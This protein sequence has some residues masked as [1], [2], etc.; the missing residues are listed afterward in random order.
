LSGFLITG[1]L[2]DEKS[3]KFSDY[4]RS[5]Y[6]KRTL[7]I[8]PLFYAYL[9]FNFLILLVTGRSTEGYGWYLLYLQNYHIGL[10]LNGSGSLP[11]IVAHTWSLAVEEQFYLVWPFLVYF[12][13]R[14]QL[15]WTCVLL[16]IASPLARWAIL[17]NDGN[18]YLTNATLP[19][20]LDMMAYGA[21]LALLRTSDIGSKV[22]YVMFAIGCALTGYAIFELGLGAFWEPQR[23]VKSAFYLFTAL[24]FIFGMAIWAVT[25]KPNANLVRMLTVRPLLFTGKISYGLYIW[26]F[27]IFLAVEKFAA[28][29]NVPAMPLVAPLISLVLAYVVSTISFYFFEIHFLRLKDKLV[30]K[31]RSAQF[32]EA[33]T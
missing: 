11:G 24:A 8:F 19:S 32:A 10:E 18:V 28:K 16:I 5:F 27:I 4:L 23:W 26:H 7:R 14:R 13:S 17:Q 33:R 22:A 1:I 25:V 6:M 31:K 12:V 30:A 3:S 2:L 29:V 9:A 15:A 20:C 21:L